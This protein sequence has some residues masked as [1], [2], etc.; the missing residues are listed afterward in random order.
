LATGKKLG[1]ALLGLGDYATQQLAPALQHTKHCR[2]AGIVTGMAAKIPE[3]K[4]KYNLPDKNIYNYDDYNAI[5]N[6]PDI[7][8]VYIVLPNNLHASYSIRALEAGKHVI[9]EKPLATTVEDCDKMIAAA[10]KAKRFLS[11]GYRL[12]FDPY[13]AEMVRLAKEKIFGDI[14]SIEVAFSFVPGKGAWRMD[15]NKSGG[16]PL[17]DLGIYCLHAVCNITGSLPIS[18]TGKSYKLSD[19]GKFNGVEETLSWEMEMPGGITA[20]CHTSYA[21]QNGFIKV[22]ASNGWFEL[23]PGFNY[24]GL[25]MITSDNRKF[26]LP[27]YSQQV[28]QLDG[29]ALAINNNEPGIAAGELGRRDLQLIAAIYK[30]VQTGKRVAV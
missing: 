2:L 28:I 5:K 14:K 9:C 6:N 18:V 11:V 10:E 4:R 13:H 17:M 8:I 26:E 24:S 15:K 1:V 27:P 21:E 29:I 30:A 12:Q 19:P 25:Q 16:G 22:T 20:Y 7:D 3:W 23:N